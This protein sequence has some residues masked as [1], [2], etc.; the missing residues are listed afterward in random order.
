MRSLISCV[1]S[2]TP[3]CSSRLA[4]VSARDRIRVRSSPDGVYQIGE[5][6]ARSWIWVGAGASIPNLAASYVVQRGVGI[7]STRA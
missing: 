4:T 6:H 1:V 7:S 5:L 2:A 3:P